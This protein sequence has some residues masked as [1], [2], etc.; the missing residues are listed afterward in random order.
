M[1]AKKPLTL[2]AY[3]EGRNKTAF[4][5]ACG[6][7]H[8]HQIFAYVRR[9]NGKP[10]LKRIGADVAR[11]IVRASGGALTFETLLGEPE[12]PPAQQEAA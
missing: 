9:R 11:R 12:T 4:G 6:F 8:G 3:L 7:K 10:P 5:R 1:E 2:E